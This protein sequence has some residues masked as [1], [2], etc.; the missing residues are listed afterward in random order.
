MKQKQYIAFDP[1]EGYPAGRGIFYECCKCG[2]DLPSA[3]VGGVACSCRNVVVD[4]DAGR[5]SVKNDEQL[6]IFSYAG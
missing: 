4:G 5:V 1:P 2:D 6:K 3:P